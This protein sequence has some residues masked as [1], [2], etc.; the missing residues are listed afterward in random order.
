MNLDAA[1]RELK[2]LLGDRLS[3]AA[4]VREHHGT[5]LSYHKA[6]APDAV[7]FAQST[8]DVAR[9]V[10]SSSDSRNT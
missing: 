7:A 4:A 10:R 9:I 8:E 3:T 1:L 6:H 2:S 5:D